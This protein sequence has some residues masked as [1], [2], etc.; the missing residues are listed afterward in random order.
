MS[1]AEAWGLHLSNLLVGGSGVAYGW[2]RYL[3]EPADEFAVVNH[4]W[5]PDT[6][7]LHVLVAPLLVFGVGLVWNAHVWRR[8]RSGFRPHRRSGA[9]LAL[10]FAPMVA[11]GYLVQVA[12]GALW[13]EAW[14][15]THGLTSLAWLALAFSHPFLPRGRRRGGSDGAEKG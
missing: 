6:Q 8:W 13:R 9:A 1:R 4:P 3:A 2:M 11:S 15:W 7:H 5:Q 12:E 10:L 14:A